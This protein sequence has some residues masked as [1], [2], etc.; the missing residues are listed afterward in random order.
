MSVEELLE[1][2]K[3]AYASDFEV[4]SGSG[5]KVSSDSEVSGDEEV[6][7]EEDESDAESNTSSSG[8]KQLSQGIKI[9]SCKLFIFI[10]VFHKGTTCFSILFKD[11]ITWFFFY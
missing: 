4:P 8:I 3:G 10:N 7:T 2:Y 9:I 1:K 6:E 11:S 5:S